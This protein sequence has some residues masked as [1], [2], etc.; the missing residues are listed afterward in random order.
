MEVKVIGAGLAGS[1]A[2]WQLAKRGILVSIVSLSAGRFAPVV[3]RVAGFGTLRLSA[4]G[5]AGVNLQPDCFVFSMAFCL[6]SHIVF[7]FIV[8]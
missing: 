4:P 2:A 5:S 3:F 6:V 8:E 7:A 1:E